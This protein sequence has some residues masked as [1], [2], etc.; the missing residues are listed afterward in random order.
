MEIVFQ[1]SLFQLFFILTVV[2]LAFG[3][4]VIF[5]IRRYQF[6]KRIQEESKLETHLLRMLIDQ[7]PDFIYI[8]DLQSRFIIANKFLAHIHQMDNPEELTGKTDFDLYP[9]EMAL[10]F[11]NDEQEIIRT[12]EALISIEEEGFDE[13]KNKI[14]ISTTKVPWFDKNDKVQGI[15]GI[16]RDVTKF[17]DIERSLMKQTTY[18]QEF[19]VLLEEK[20]EHINYQREELTVQADNLKF[21]NQELQKMNTTKDKFI[22]IIAHDLKNPFNAII[23][24]SELLILK[25]DDSIKPKQLEMIKIINSSSKT[26][27]SLLENLLYWGKSQNL[28]IPFRP[29]TFN[30]SVII[31]EVVDFHEV[32]ARLKHIEMINNSATD[33]SVFADRDMVTTI[34][35]NLVSNAIKFTHKEGK[36]V[37]SNSSVEKI[38]YITVTDSGLGISKTQLNRLFKPTKEISRGTSGESGTGLG[39]LLCKEFALKNGGDIFVKSEVRKGASFILSLPLPAEF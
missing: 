31:K 3:I 19:N 17:K 30:I 12:K 35:R 37:I 6:R 39:L 36:I 2:L 34:L 24:F 8:K 32:S 10:K 15:I 23:N 33:L 9:K 26:A 18:L 4:G 7:M 14:I 25:A 27:Y 29:E 11:Y 21:L 38:G 28:S 16:G 13:K 22:S 5:L 20:H 1:I